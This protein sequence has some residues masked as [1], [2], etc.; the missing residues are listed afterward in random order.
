ML[1]VSGSKTSI[2]VSLPS[3]IGKDITI[4]YGQET[5]MNSFGT[6][7][8]NNGANS[9]K[10]GSSAG[11]H[12]IATLPTNDGKVI[13]EYSKN[14]ILTT[15]MD[16]L[17]VNRIGESIYTD[18]ELLEDNPNAHKV[19]ISVAGL[20]ESSYGRIIN[21]VDNF[22]HKYS[23]VWN[24]TNIELIIPRGFEMTASIDAFISETGKYYDGVSIVITDDIDEY[25]MLFTP[26]TGLD[27]SGA[28][29]KYMTSDC[30]YYIYVGKQNAIAW[31]TTGVSI[32]DIEVDEVI[33]SQTDGYQNT[34]IIAAADSSALMFSKAQ[35]FKLLGQNLSGYIPSY[36]EVEVI[37]ANITEINQFLANNGKA[38]LD[39]SN[40]WVSEAFDANNA[41]AF[42][43]TTP[44]DKSLTK[45]YYI[46]GRRTNM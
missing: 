27:L 1:T 4:E 8:T 13:I 14:S 20:N 26:I 24:G 25:E 34:Q 28:T 29:L 38:S 22:G 40:T 16:G 5:A 42:G 41:W 45:K 44:Q 46:F 31:G 35:S 15:N 33:S 18:P 32:P 17:V 23:K 21:I 11:Y 12:Q 30:D 19:T 43:E 9:V 39:F 7:S 6:I 3:Y 37:N 2:E 36:A 10:I